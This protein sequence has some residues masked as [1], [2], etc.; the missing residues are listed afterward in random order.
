MYLV[1]ILKSLKTDNYYVGSTKD[2]NKRIKEHNQGKTKSTKGLRPLKLIY[3]ENFS[4]NSRARK[5]ELEIKKRKS[6]KYIETLIK[7][8]K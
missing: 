7:L 1:Y 2:L 4:T 3:F 6:R 8:K 5:R